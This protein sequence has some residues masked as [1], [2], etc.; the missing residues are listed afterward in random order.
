LKV[1]AHEVESEG[2]VN[3]AIEFDDQ[4]EENSAM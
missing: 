1:K 4:K 2:I 3:S